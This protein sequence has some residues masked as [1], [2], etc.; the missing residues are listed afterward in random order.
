MSTI[1]PDFKSSHLKIKRANK[2]IAEIN[3]LVNDFARSD[4][5]AMR[6]E[7]DGPLRYL[8]VD[9]DTSRFPFD[10][11]AL[12]IGDALHN[13][14]TSLDHLWYQIVLACGGKTTQWTRFPVF[15]SGDKLVHAMN[16]ALKHK[17]ITL[18]V[19][20]FVLDTIKPYQGGNTFIWPLHVLNITDKHEMLVPMLQLMQISDLRLE[21]HKTGKVIGQSS[22]IIDSSAR[23]RL[24]DA[25]RKKVIVKDKGHAAAAILFDEGTT[26]WGEPVVP[27]LVWIAEEVTRTVK[28][29]EI[30]L[31]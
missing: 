22:Y 10:D 1:M 26:M 13:L 6:I 25:Y 18:K 31:S 14:R 17:R 24:R 11:A 3:S 20:E 4:F 30:L 9:V 19:A 7:N 2:Y 21:E 8:C 27:A 12:A 23:I 29:F 16:D 28:A 5:Y 15:D